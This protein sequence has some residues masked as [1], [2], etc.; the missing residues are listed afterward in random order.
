MRQLVAR[1]LDQTC[2]V[3]EGG[4]AA[5]A[6]RLAVPR[7]AVLDVGEVLALE[8]LRQDAG[9]LALDGARLVEGG[10]QGGDVVAVDDDC[11][12]AEGLDASPVSHMKG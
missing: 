11:V 9:G 12:P 8:G 2:D 6:E 10:D 3:G 4:L 7:G 5:A 1:R